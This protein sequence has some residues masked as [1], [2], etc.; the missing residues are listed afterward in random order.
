MDKLTVFISFPSSVLRQ[1]YPYNIS[2][3]SRWFQVRDNRLQAYELEY[4]CR[5]CASPWYTWNTDK[6]L[7]QLTMKSVAGESHL[8]D[9][10]KAVKHTVYYCA[11]ESR[12]GSLC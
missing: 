2:S 10:A 4:I 11:I 3:L 12:H 8:Y 1:D 7:Y 6:T 9:T 5:E